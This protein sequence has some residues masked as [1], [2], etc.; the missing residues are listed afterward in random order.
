MYEIF[1]K[2]VISVQAH[3]TMGKLKIIRGSIRLTLEKLPGIRGDLVGLDKD[4][5]Q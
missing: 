4:W 5:Q 3:D 1:E 2:L